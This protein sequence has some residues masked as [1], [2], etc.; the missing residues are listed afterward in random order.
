MRITRAVVSCAFLLT[1]AAGYFAPNAPSAAVAQ[2]AADVA[3]PAAIVKPRAF[4]SLAPVPRGKEFQVAVA[5][6]IA[7]GYHM[8]S[9]HPTD[10][11]LIAT[12]LTPKLPTGFE[13]LDTLYPAGRVEKFSFSPDKGLDVYSGRVTLKLRM[14]AHNDAPIGA[15]TFAVT[16]RYQACNDTTCL[17]PVKVPV[18]VRV[19]VAA[20]GTATHAAH[21]EIFSN[22]PAK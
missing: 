3:S 11:Y 16:L 8:N 10:Q 21:P 4:V 5:V 22:S 2:S 19:D 20:A 1:L 17:P 18:D 6:E 15:V 9:H 14:V 12:T 13:V 7:H